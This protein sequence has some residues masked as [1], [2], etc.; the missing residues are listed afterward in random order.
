MRNKKILLPLVVLVTLALLLVI[1]EKTRVTNFIKLNP[2]PAVTN[3]GPTPEQKQQAAEAD[4]NAKKQ[5][6]E[7][8]DPSTSTPNKNPATENTIDLSTQQEA[9]G[10]VTVFT[11]LS[12]YTSGTCNLNIT[13]GGKTTTQAAA[14]YYQPEFSSCAGFS[15]PISSA[16][17]GTWSLTLTV[18]SNG[19]STSKTITAKVN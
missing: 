11:K 17:S 3:Q 15:V 9:N 7:S 13:N 16:G 4:A 19:S 18:T 12:G 10:T 8:P 1:L 14:I 2:E 6:I 5:L